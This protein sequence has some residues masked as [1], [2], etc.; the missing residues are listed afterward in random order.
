MGV[1]GHPTTVS[2]NANQYIPA[3]L[4]IHN[5][6]VSIRHFDPYTA[7]PESFKLLGNDIT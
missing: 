5:Q 6:G 3:L 1:L 2:L 4:T 7:L